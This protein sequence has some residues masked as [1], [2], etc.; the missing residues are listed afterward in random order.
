MNDRWPQVRLGE[1]LSRSDETSA[2]YPDV[3]YREITI[4]LWGKGVVPRGR[5]SGAEL[6][7]TRRFVAR[8]GQFILSRIDARNG[9]IGLVPPELDGAVVSNDFPTFVIDKTRV[10]E[11]FLG[12]MTRALGFVEMCRRASEGTTNRVRLQEDRFLAL[13]I[14]LPPLLEQQRLATWIDAISTEL[15]RIRALRSEQKVQM[16]SL[17]VGNFHR[18]THDAPRIPMREVAPLVRRPVKVEVDKSYA[19]LGIR[20]FGNGTFHKPAITGLELGNKRI[21]KIEPGDLVFNNVFA[22]EGAIAVARAEDKGRVG[23]HRFITCVTNPE[24]ATS[25][26]L[27]FYF[28]TEEGLAK[29]QAASPGGALRNRTLGLEALADIEVPLP[30]MDDQRSFEAI[31]DQ[32]DRLAEGHA[33]TE[34]ELDA[35]L[36]S[37]LDRAFNGSL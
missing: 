11:R 9:A 23:S 29:I 34:P 4:K 13:E 30:T 12:W 25:R 17:L 10:N 14:G 8:S 7:G 31:Y 6:A 18:I 5:I 3:E 1:L 35:L 36:P 26:F 32:V 16:R 15:S 19:E 21:F 22:W 28:L 2:V 20:S 27:C 37:V 24:A 33:T